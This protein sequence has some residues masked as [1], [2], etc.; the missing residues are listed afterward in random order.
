MDLDRTLDL[1]RLG[2]QAHR[3]EEGH[4]L[5]GAALADDAEQL[6]G[7]DGDV[8]AADRLHIAAFGRERDAQVADLE[9]WLSR[10]SRPIHL[11]LG[12]ERVTQARRRRS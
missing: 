9:Y 8:D 6:T 5:A 11:R 10:R 3:R 1:G 4:R 7:A 12:I 2:Q